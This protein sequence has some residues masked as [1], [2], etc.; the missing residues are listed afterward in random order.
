MSDR[1]DITIVREC[2]RRKA[3]AV[4]VGNLRVWGSKPYASENLPSESF[5]VSIHEMEK[6][7]EFARNHRAA[8]LGL[9]ES[10]HD[11]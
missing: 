1:I 3:R 2:D 4:Y 10:S 9:P 11:R 8:Q 7:L 5:S 6:A